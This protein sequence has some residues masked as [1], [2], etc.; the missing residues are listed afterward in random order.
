MTE[1][2]CGKCDT[3]KAERDE[4]VEALRVIAGIGRKYTKDTKCLVCGTYS[5]EGQHYP[6]CKAGEVLKKLGEL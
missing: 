5:K 1:C 3:L 4:A 2:H 6:Y